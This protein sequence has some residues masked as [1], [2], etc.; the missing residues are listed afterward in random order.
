MQVGIGELAALTGALLWAIASVV[1]GR[2]V[3]QRLPA[4]LLNLLKGAIAIVLLL[5]TLLSQRATFPAVAGAAVGGLWLSGVVGIGLGDT[6]YLMAL[7]QLG[8]RR[9]LLLETLAPPITALLAWLVLGE[10]LS[11]AAIAGIGITMVG[12]GWVI[13]ERN[14]AQPMKAIVPPLNWRGLSWGLLAELAQGSGA[15]LSRQALADTA[16]TPLWSSLIRLVGGEMILVVLLAVYQWRGQTLGS[17]CWRGGKMSERGCLAIALAAF[18]GTYLGIW[19]QQTA[20]KHAPTGIAQTLLATSPLFVLPIVAL[21]GET[22]TLRSLL[23]V[24][25]A[26]VGIALLFNG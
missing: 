7:S 11:G 10:Q 5:L 21:L 26:L 8:V 23:G 9:A 3:G 6:A 4:L 14:S 16:M 18:G 25:I 2:M 22:L 1:Y 20:L 17:S 12:V 19:C 13:V 15:V 24:V